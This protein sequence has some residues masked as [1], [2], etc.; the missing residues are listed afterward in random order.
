MEGLENPYLNS[1]GGQYGDNGAV[2][3]PYLNMNPEYD[4][5]Y[6]EE[7]YGEYSQE[8]HNPPDSTF[9]A[10]SQQ[11][12]DGGV[13]IS[14]L[15]FDTK[16]DLLWMGNQSG[17]VTSYYGPHLQKYTSFQVH[18]S[19]GIR[20]VM[21]CDMGVLALSQTSLR[22]QMR[23]GIPVFTHTSS[24]MTEMQCML[25]Y[26]SM[27]TSILM[28]GIQDKLI[29]LDLEKVKETQT[30]DT[31][32]SCAVLRQHGRFLGCGDTSGKIQLRDPLNMKVCHTLDT[33][34]GTLSDFDMNGHHL[35]TCGFAR[36]HGNLQ[37]VDRFLMVYDLR[38]MRSVNPIQCLVEPCQLRFLPSMTSR[39]V[40]L[41]ASGQVQL[42]DTADIS[43]ATLDVFQID[44]SG[45][46]VLSMDVSPS[47]HCLG[48]GDENN[49]LHIFSNQTDSEAPSFNLYPKETEFAD[50]TTTFPSMSISDPHANLSSIPLPHLPVEQ[51]SFAS[52]KWP[53]RYARE[54]YRP[55]PEI[56]PAIFEV[57]KMVGTIGYAPNI[58]N[59]R[60]NVVGYNLKKVDNK[61]PSNQELNNSLTKEDSTYKSSVP[62]RYKK[63]EIKYSKL[64]SDDFDF[65]HY[66][67]TSFCGLEASLPNSYCNAMLQILYFTEHFR[68]IILN[69]FCTRESCL[70]CEVSYLFH[71]LD[72]GQGMPC[73][74]ANFL[75][76]LRTIPE[77]SA[78]GLVF[79]EANTIWR[80]SVPRLIQSWTRFLLQQ[81]HL[82]CSDMA[83]P[84]TPP[85]HSLSGAPVGLAGQLAASSAD[86]SRLSPAKKTP[87]QET[88]MAE[89]QDM[90]ELLESNIS[91]KTE[92]T[93]EESQIAQLFGMRQDKVTK[94][95]KCLNTVTS[96]NLLLLCNLT[97]PEH[98]AARDQVTFAEVL[99]SSLCPEQV[100]PAWC[101][102]CRKYQ[103]TSQ[104]RKLK[105]LP[106]NLSVNAGMDNPADITFW[107]TQME[108][109]LD[110]APDG[111]APMATP[112]SASSASPSKPSSGPPLGQKACRYSGSCTR[113]D[114]K[115]WHA[116]QDGVL[117]EPTLDVGDKLAKL[118]KSWV[119]FNVTLYLG[120][121]GI[122]R[123]S[124][125]TDVPTAESRNYSLYAV[126]SNVVDPVNPEATSLVSCVRVGPSYHARIGSPVSQ[127]YIFND[128]TITPI[129]QQEAV[130]FNLKWKIPCI[131]CYQ[132]TDIPTHLQGLEY[133]NPITV[134][135]FGED[136]SL[137]QR[138]GGK[139][140][141]FQ[142]LGTDEM[143]NPGTL[144]AIDAEFVTLN[145]EESELRSD[146]KVSTVKAAHMSVARI[147][148]VRGEGV[149]EGV[150]FIDD[151]ISTQEQ[152][153]DY[154]TKFSGIK[155]GDLDANFSSKHLT[156]LKSTYQKLRFLVDTKVTFIGHGL[157]NDFRVINLVVP[158][159][160]VIDTVHLFHLPHHRM[161]SLKFLSW[162]FLKVKIQGV[163][164]DSIEDAVTSLRLYRKYLEF[165]KENKVME[166][167]NG[168]YEVGKEC[169]WKI[170]QERRPIN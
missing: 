163:T 158:Q 157:K 52:D 165:K 107:H 108:M 93:V 104:M 96:D 87:T 130:W 12:G 113:P 146:G 92:D 136:K 62:K 58:G 17:H 38:I 138:A 69:H 166:A 131:L 15:A 124:Q 4:G 137:L 55:T 5:V 161:V 162:Y 13:G 63:N 78:L 134:D 8:Y 118:Q 103:P 51:K 144:V 74:P 89:F 127:W 91:K 22:C 71:M 83:R 42:V 31:G 18:N 140:L 151:Y 153:V 141:T 97:Y 101:D 14:A 64:G 86:W 115:F 155:P 48:F 33:H 114:C 149:M 45:G 57:M 30:M 60:R 122:V 126:C 105:T 147:T 150:P 27:P 76:A 9:Q 34:S 75:R 111:S 59:K 168:L 152:V 160:Q 132:A 102:S 170:P 143:P 85:P 7:D 10:F 2:E 35:V 145:Q 6:T 29:V 81:V 50:A 82:Q 112:Q 133:R 164:H 99:C 61:N 25:H 148:C 156:T 40:V 159:D 117:K 120:Q 44:T 128:F 70:A 1:N 36:R 72:I 21:S 79:T 135:V 39:I 66:N 47:N 43:N 119:P 106:S 90:A 98:A 142:V 41:S 95:S 37:A 129:P 54:V 109:I 53:D 56:D 73:Q 26:P 19:E 116:G 46:M 24:S 123:T 3:N 139:R 121:D 11:V 100:T 20:S 80:T 94:C 32:G 65:D 88:S 169:N 67:K 68:I 16:E 110:G 23:R 49:R 77:A 125:D 28:G 84:S 167:L 154:L